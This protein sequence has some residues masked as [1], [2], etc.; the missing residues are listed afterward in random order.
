MSASP[1][2]RKATNTSNEDF[3]LPPAGLHPAVLIGLVDLGTNTEE[4]NN[5]E[6]EKHELFVAW[7]LVG[8]KNN[9]D[10]PFV[11]GQDYNESLGK[12][13]NWRKLLEGWRG[14][15]FQ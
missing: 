2:K 9:G 1:F 10:E 14:R 7:E 3:E 4:Y 8:T 12:K 13:S 15:P 6:Y 11:V 5:K